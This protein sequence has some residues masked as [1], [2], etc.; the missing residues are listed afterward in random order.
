VD[1]DYL[2]VHAGLKPGIPLEKQSEADLFA[3]RDEF[4]NSPAVFE[5]VVVHGHSI[6]YQVEFRDNRIGID[7]GAFASGRLTCPVLEGTERE[8]LSS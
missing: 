2:F 7:T 6:S 3:I 4:L 1:G 8:I 5:R